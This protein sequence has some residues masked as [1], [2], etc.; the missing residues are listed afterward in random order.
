MHRTARTLGSCAPWKEGSRTACATA[1]AAMARTFRMGLVLALAA[2]LNACA[3]A[4]AQPRYSDSK[5][6]NGPDT[7]GAPGEGMPDPA[8]ARH[9][10][11]D[12]DEDDGA[13]ET[14]SGGAAERNANRMGWLGVEL[15]AHHDGQAGIDV[16]DVVRRS[17]AAAAGIAAGDSIVQLDGA[18]ISDPMTFIKRIR[19]TQPG[20]KLSIGFLRKGELR[21]ASVDVEAAPSPDDLIE[22]R[23][24][25]QSA[26]PLDGLTMV[27][28]DTAAN[29]SALRGQ[30]VVLEFWAPWCGVC[31]VMHQRLNEWHTQWSRY[32]V[33]VI[34]IAA[35][36]PEEA[37]R[38][39]QRFGM[40]YSVAADTDE[41]VFRSYDVFAV[42]S[43]F[44]VDRRGTIAFATMG[45]STQR[46]ADMEKKLIALLGA[47][48]N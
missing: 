35:L 37:R 21:L 7:L 43:V 40:G 47:E 33:R 5:R 36:A 10:G 16:V 26:P 23:F 8:L 4:T 20:T 34:G 48:A 13:A 41:A 25:G 19:K 31:R 45:Y 6:V 11:N 32:G 12:S 24:V 17:P 44:L 18:T 2:Q 15:Q 3:S 9:R 28:G 46:V 38:F 27:E 14:S 30:L 29:W 39:A 42:P 1:G 22:R